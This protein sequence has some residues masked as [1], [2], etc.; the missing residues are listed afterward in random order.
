MYPP[1]QIVNLPNDIVLS[2]IWYPDGVESSEPAHGASDP[3]LV[4]YLLRR[5]RQR[6][7]A[8]TASGLAGGRHPRDIALLRVISRE[9]SRHSAVARRLP[10]HQPVGDG[11]ADRRARGER[12]RR[13]RTGGSTTAVRMPF[14]RRRP[15]GGRSRGCQSPS[16]ALDGA[17]SASLSAD[18]TRR[19]TT[20]LRSVVLPHFDPAPPVELTDLIGFLIAHAYLRFEALGDSLLQPL[21]LTV[22]TFA[23]LATIDRGGPCS[24]QE[25]ADRLE[26]RPAATVELIDELE[27]L[28]TVRRS[29]NPADR[30]SY[31]LELTPLGERPPR[32]VKG[33]LERGARSAPG[34]SRRGRAPPA[35]QSCSPSSPAWTKHR[36]G[37]RA[38]AHR[39]RRRSLSRS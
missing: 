31:A 36:G 12:G 27:R 9:R 6:M 20:L 17:F 4:C 25:L 33:L 10:R 8:S 21:G 18:E 22:R 26:I 14:A 29:R 5:V 32:P 23:A 13:P 1:A 15:A 3:A 28:G 11:E 19:L 37:G 7:L 35:R 2:T 38:P 39:R 34:P 24:Q 16:A 30:R